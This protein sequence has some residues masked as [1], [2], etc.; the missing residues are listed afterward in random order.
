MDFPQI[1]TQESTRKAEHNIRTKE[2]HHPSI[3]PEDLRYAFSV[4]LNI[5][6]AS[7]KWTSSCA[8]ILFG[9]MSFNSH[10]SAQYCFTGLRAVE[11][12]VFLVWIAGAVRSTAWFSFLM[13]IPAAGSGVANCNRVTVGIG[14]LFSAGRW[15]SFHA[16]IVLRNALQLHRYTCQGKSGRCAWWMSELPRCVQLDRWFLI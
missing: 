5:S 8:P 14:E 9:S 10:H 15:P 3:T 12:A 16:F 1:A 4:T 11:K 2:T 7:L 13:W 6:H